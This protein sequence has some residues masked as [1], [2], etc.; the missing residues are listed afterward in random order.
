MKFIESKPKSFFY[1]ILLEILVLFE[2]SLLS[3]FRFV[4]PGSAKDK[5]LNGTTVEKIGSLKLMGANV[6]WNYIVCSVLIIVIM[7]IFAFV[8]G[9]NRNPGGLYA[10][11]L[12]NILPFIGLFWAYNF[13]WAFGTS[14]FAPAMTIFGLQKNG[15]NT[16]GQSLFIIAVLI[17]LVVVW[18]IGKKVRAEYAKKYEF[19]F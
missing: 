18:L 16:L 5:Y 2:M 17:L 11:L 13:F 9:Y 14:A 6:G 4:Q 7:L 3:G 10:M 8:L 12:M 1:T 15:G 19:D